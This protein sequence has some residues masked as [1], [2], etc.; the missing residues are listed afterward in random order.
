VY[1]IE[2]EKL[3]YK[4]EKFTSVF[5]E[6][7][8]EGLNF[9]LLLFLV[10]VNFF[11]HIF[12]RFV[13]DLPPTLFK[14]KFITVYHLCSSMK[15]LRDYYYPTGVLT[16]RSKKYFQA[17]L[18]DKDLLLIG[19]QVNLR[20]NLVHYGIE[21]IP[22]DKLNPTADL[23]GLIEYFLH[24][25]TYADVNEELDKQIARISGVLEE[26]LNWSIQSSQISKWNFS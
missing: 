9:S 23:Y 2:D 1:N 3:G 4:D 22:E 16:D 10:T 24:G 21:E 20:K 26:W 14:L 17:I 6:A 5:N 12:K 19:K 13:T 25:Q 7:G 18:G 15:K 11:E 8:P